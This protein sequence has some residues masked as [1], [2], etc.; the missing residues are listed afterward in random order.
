MYASPL[1]K[2]NNVIFCLYVFLLLLLMPAIVLFGHHAF[3]FFASS[4]DFFA[5]S[6]KFPG[7]VSHHIGDQNTPLHV[8]PVR[9]VLSVSLPGNLMGMS[10]LEF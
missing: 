8:P 1:T 2:N 9:H 5:G 3:F 4:Q 10:A 7:N 6:A